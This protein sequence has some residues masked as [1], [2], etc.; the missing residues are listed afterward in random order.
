MSWLLAA[1]DLWAGTQWDEAIITT[2]AVVTAATVIWRKLIRPS[3]DAFH[4]GA[5]AL[6][7]IEEQMQP[8]GGESIRDKIDQLT[9]TLADLVARVAEIEAA[10]SS[11][12]SKGEPPS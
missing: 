8:N 6:R 3:V 12:R 11:S 9:A 7:W 1:I 4:S 10:L 2:A 5:K